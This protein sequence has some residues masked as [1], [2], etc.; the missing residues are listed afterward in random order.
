MAS[1]QNSHARPSH[2]FRS[3][4][5]GPLQWRQPEHARATFGRHRLNGR[6]GLSRS[7]AVVCQSERRKTGIQASHCRS[8]LYLDGK[9]VG[10][11]GL[12]RVGIQILRLE[13]LPGLKAVWGEDSRFH[14]RLAS[15]VPRRGRTFS[16]ML[17]K[18]V[19]SHAMAAAAE[20][21]R[22]ACKR[23]GE[24]ESHTGR[25]RFSSLLPLL[26]RAL[27]ARTT[28]A[29]RSAQLPAG[30][31]GRAHTLVVDDKDALER[32]PLLD[33]SCVRENKWTRVCVCVWWKCEYQQRRPALASRGAAVGGRH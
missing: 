22:G 20:P 4:C 1:A 6:H 28:L 32:Q 9:A 25:A 14:R 33:L 5:C 31:M 24:H 15:R 27:V 8:R 23:K 11:D 29:K 18:H 13:V 17:L 16:P 2:T 19:A 26:S 30:E 10:A 21:W 7:D 3:C 12:C